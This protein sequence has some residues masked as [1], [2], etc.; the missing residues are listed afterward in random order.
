MRRIF[1]LILLNMRLA[2]QD[3]TNL[4]LL[5][6]MPI[7]MMIVLALAIGEQQTT[8][9]IDV[10]N[11][12]GDDAPMA[13]QFIAQLRDVSDET[14]TVIVCV[15]GADDNPDDCELGDDL[16]NAD[17]AR[18]RLEEGNAAAAVIIPAGFSEALQRGEPVTITYQAEQGLN[19]S[20]V[21]RNT[22]DTAIGRVAGAVQIAEAGVSTAIEQFGA[23][24]NGQ[25]QAAREEAQA[26]LLERARAALAD[27]PVRVELESTG[28]D[29]NR[30]GAN[31]SVP[32]IATM[33][34]LLTA[35]NGAS[36]LVQERERGTLQRLYVLPVPKFHVVFGKLGG[37][38]AFSVMQFVIFIVVGV[39]MDV[40][41]GGNYLAIAVIVLTFALAANALGFVLATMVRTYEQA[42]GIALLLGLTLAPIGGAWWPMEIMPEFMQTIGH[43]SPIAWAMDAFSELLY[44][45]GGLVDILP[46]AG[47]LVGMAI[48]LTVIAVLRFGYE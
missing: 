37:I 41:W 28:E 21:T 17:D 48:G 38:Y 12:D 14:E 8:L 36:T 40:S 32:G 31:Q 39:L 10:V 47:V 46:M 44:Y 25:D 23:Y 18:T 42:G 15:Y 13:D 24:D 20:T 3:F 7:A 2:V 11:R 29:L 4:L 16:D 30:L 45:D 9:A 22:V 5:F 26:S 27:P 35:L 43:I 6:V 34:V 19:A 1:E 33:F